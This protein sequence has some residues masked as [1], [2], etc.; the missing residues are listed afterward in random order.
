M[1]F[2]SQ[3][4]PIIISSNTTDGDSYEV[5]KW[6]IVLMAKGEIGV[7]YKSQFCKMS[8]LLHM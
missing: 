2:R 1:K 8:I 6:L 3:R 7:L 4:P 5:V